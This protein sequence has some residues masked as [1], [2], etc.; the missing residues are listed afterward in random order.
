MCIAKYFNLFCDLFNINT[1]CCLV[2]R[3]SRN[4]QT[5][6]I[7]P[8]SQNTNIYQ[9]VFSLKDYYIDILNYSVY[10]IYNDGI[11]LDNKTDCTVFLYDKKVFKI[12]NSKNLKNYLNI[13]Y[14]IKNYNIKN[15][16]I[17]EAIYNTTDNLVQ[18]FKYYNNG[19]LFDYITNNHLSINVIKN[20][21]AQIIKIVYDLHSV[22]I[23]HLDLKLENF[24]LYYDEND[25]IKVILI[26]LDYATFNYYK[27]KFNGGTTYYAA[28]EII[29]NRQINDF[30]K[31][32]IWS[33][34]I[35]LYIF[36]FNCFPWESANILQNGFIN[37]INNYYE[38]FW[39]DS[40]KKCKYKLDEETL[41]AYSNIFKNGL[42]LKNEDRC[43]INY[44]YNLLNI[45]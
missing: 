18:I 42:I 8:K 22:G 12:T 35:I 11:G 44:I 1:F 5:K 33:L 9:L 37:Y 23:V 36:L 25:N 13:I 2:K 38:N 29:N 32:D 27:S 45:E 28:Y 39:Y 10:N 31:C 26:D 16:L 21:Y 3:K 17:P 41:I 6:K 14:T 30:N 40:L 20:L 19:D 43:N 15:V 7:S 34:C 24:L 4:K